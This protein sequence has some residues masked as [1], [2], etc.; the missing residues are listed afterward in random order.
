MSTFFAHPF[1]LLTPPDS[2]PPVLGNST[3]YFD[4]LRYDN[5]NFFYAHPFILLAARDIPSQVLG[6]CT[7][8]VG[9]LD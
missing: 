2:P 6:N 1:I 5:V 8:N 4:R 9:S 3:L 7:L